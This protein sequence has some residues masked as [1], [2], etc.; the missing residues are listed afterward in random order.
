[1]LMKSVP[2]GPTNNKPALPQIM[3]WHWT[4]D[5]PLSD[6]MMAWFTDTYI[7]SSL[8]SDELIWKAYDEDPE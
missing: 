7:H 8:G 2:K 5:K 1:M 4:G 3:A 6:T